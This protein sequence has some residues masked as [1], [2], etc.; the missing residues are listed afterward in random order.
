MGMETQSAASAQ[1]DSDRI[2]QEHSF[3]IRDMQKKQRQEVESLKEKHEN[4]MKGMESAY[5]VEFTS[6]KDGFDKKLAELDA[7]QTNR[8]ALTTRSN[9]MSLKQAQET[10]RIQAE[11]LANRGEKKLNALREQTAMAEEN[12]TRKKGNA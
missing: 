3:K 12:I 11:E 9:D 7:G 8:L 2:A 6:Q 4:E 5:Q 1:P 10:Y